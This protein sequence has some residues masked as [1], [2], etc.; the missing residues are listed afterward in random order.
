MT[1]Q[2]QC[3][4]CIHCEICKHCAPRKEIQ[5]LMEKTIGDEI[6][7]PLIFSISCTMFKRKDT[8]DAFGKEM[9]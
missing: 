2:K 4:E 1:K 3:T 7:V 6:Q 5:E 8:W 9:L